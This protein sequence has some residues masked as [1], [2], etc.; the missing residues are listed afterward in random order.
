MKKLIY[1]IIIFMIFTSC[2][3]WHTDWAL[4][5][6]YIKAE[7]CPELI[8][9]ERQ[10]LPHPQIPLFETTDVDGNPIE[11]NEAYLIRV[12]V[13]LF[14]TVEKFQYL[15]EIYEREYL[16]TGGKIMPDLTL[17]ELKKLYQE[18]LGK[19]EEIIEESPVLETTNMILGA[20]SDM[21][22]SEFEI[23]FEE[24]E[25]LQSRMEKE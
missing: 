12:I 5:N 8:V 19:V 2:T 16:N 4:S 3:T 17:E 21:K 15:V 1:I 24:W 7:D 6:G 11:I 9:P 25:R 18:R 20:S 13:Q 14:G 22:V 10:A 23:L